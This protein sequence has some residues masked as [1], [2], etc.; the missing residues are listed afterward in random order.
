MIRK[1]FSPMH[2]R[3]ARL[4]L[5]VSLALAD[6]HAHAREPAAFPATPAGHAVMPTAI[7]VLPTNCAHG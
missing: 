2:L 3:H 5:M 6:L 7:S 1:V 4:A